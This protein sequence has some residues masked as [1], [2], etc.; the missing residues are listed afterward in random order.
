MNVQNTLDP[1]FGIHLIVKATF[2]I[3]SELYNHENTLYTLHVIQDRVLPSS[4]E[5][6]HFSV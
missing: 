4:P 2:D 1:S 3:H 5:S 6:G